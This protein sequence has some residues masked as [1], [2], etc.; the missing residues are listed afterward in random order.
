MI[1]KNAEILFL[2]NRTMRELGSGDIQAGM[3]DVKRIYS[4]F[5]Y[6]NE[7]G[8]RVEKLTIPDKVVLRFGKGNQ[9]EYTDGRIN[10][11]PGRVHDD[12]LDFAGIKWIGSGVHN[13]ELG[14]PRANAVVILNDPY[15]KLPIC[16]ADGT[17]VSA[18]RT[19]ASGGIAVEL[20]ARKDASVLTICGAGVQGRTQLKAAVI[21][22]PG[23]KEVGIYDKFPANAQAYVDEMSKQYP[24]ISF[25]TI[26]EDDLGENVAKSDIVITASTAEHP[27][28][29]AEWVTKGTLLANISGEEME[30]GC[31]LKAD[32]T[33]VDFWQSVKHRNSSTIARMVNDPEG[34]HQ[35]FVPTAEIG[36]IINGQKPG[37][38]NDDEIIY[39]NPVGAGVLDMIIVHRCYETAV[40]EGKGQKLIFWEGDE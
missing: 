16:I 29:K 20:L 10:A 18:T 24:Q 36:E 37:R 30:R 13:Y 15:T 31:V 3:A 26:S 40:R 6:K 38:E 5:N 25:H 23:I 1:M 17:E 27:F 22:R 21:A 7:R 28:I 14:Y 2:N 32:K 9:S 8:E 11:M 34:G 35:D 12:D 4:L 39:Y 19:G 33:V